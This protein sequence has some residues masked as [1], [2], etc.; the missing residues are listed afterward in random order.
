MISGRRG[1]EKVL[2]YTPR[3]PSG[4][5]EGGREAGGGAAAAAM[6]RVAACCSAMLATGYSTSSA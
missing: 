1:G 3:L 4:R 5:V 6:Q 2:Y